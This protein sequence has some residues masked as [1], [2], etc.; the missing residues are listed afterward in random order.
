MPRKIVKEKMAVRK[1]LND[2]VKNRKR[3]N[4]GTKE[5]QWCREKS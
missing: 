4:D 3:E 2:A 1:K 5:A